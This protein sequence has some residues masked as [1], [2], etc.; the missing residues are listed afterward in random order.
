MKFV[1][2][3]AFVSSYCF[4]CN[5]ENCELLGCRLKKAEFSTNIF[6]NCEFK[7]VDLGGSY[8]K[9]SR[10]T[11]TKFEE[12]SLARTTVCN[13]KIKTTTFFG[14]QWN[15]SDQLFEVERVYSG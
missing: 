1:L 6:T 11:E 14:F 3:I 13:L 2:R 10:F 4:D 5:F 15:L 8:L 7:K 9:D 12:I